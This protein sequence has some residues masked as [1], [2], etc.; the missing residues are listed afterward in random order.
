[1]NMHLAYPICNRLLHIPA[2]YDLDMSE[3]GDRLRAARERAGFVSAKSAADALGIPYPTYAQHESGERGYPATKA[4]R[5]AQ[6]FRVT[7]QWL[8]YG[9]GDGPSATVHP[10]SRPRPINREIP[11]M[12]EVAAGLWRD[13]MPKEIHEAEEWLPVDVMGYERAALYALRVVGTSM[14]KV[15]APGRYVI[16]AP[17]A[18]AG[19]RDGDYVIVE[20]SRG[21]IVELTVK[22]VGTDGARLALW[23]RSTDPLYQTP[24]YITG[25]PDDQSAPRIIGVVV[26]DFGKRDRPVTML[27]IPK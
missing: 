15:Y 27:T 8:L 2:L 1:M 11:V 14:N 16:V 21:D 23:P 4:D 18:E 6:F 17:A 26:A 20:R 7:P 5:Y 12:G 9:R 3:K 22:E 25:D 19:I 24:L 10:I 13:A